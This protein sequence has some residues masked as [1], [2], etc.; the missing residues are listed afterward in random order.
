M[1]LLKVE[2]LKKYF[3]LNKGWF[4]KGKLLKAVDDI[5]FA[6]N[7]RETLGIVGESGCGKT[8]AAKTILRLYDL[9]DGRVE[10]QGRN[11]HDLSR[12]ETKEAR[13]DMQ[14]IFQNPV[15]SLDPRMKIRDIVGEGLDIH[16]LTENRAEKIVSV[17][18]RVGI[19]S[20]YID[21]YPHE[22]SGGQRQ[23][24]GIARALILEPK[25]IIADEPVSALDV[26]MQA[27]IINLLKELQEEYNMAYLL[28]AHDLSVVKHVS[29][30]IAVM[31][32]GKIVELAE[33]KDLCNNPLHPYTQALLSAVPVPNP[34]I[35]TKK[36]ILK[37][38]I[39]S[40]L[41]PPAGCRFHTRC[42]L[43]KNICTREEPQRQEINNHQ[44]FCHLLS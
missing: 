5:S 3:S 11:L 43:A 13:K 25:M 37:G 14:I 18:E 17:L 9:T 36:L 40:P 10:F 21:R 41:N 39:P 34:E 26:S 31:Y 42:P 4:K 30:R 8:T 22:F 35:K 29:H 28:I 44:V 7:E 33:A 19:S 15:S 27:Q 38:D 1:S 20:D 2:N 6:L 23:R 16:G 12:K 32:L 24:I